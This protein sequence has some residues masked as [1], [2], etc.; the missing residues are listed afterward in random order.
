VLLPSAVLLG[1]PPGK[2]LVAVDQQE[3]WDV[4]SAAMRKGILLRVERLAEVA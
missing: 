1:M 2:L 4:R 3:A